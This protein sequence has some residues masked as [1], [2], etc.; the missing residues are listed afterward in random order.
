MIF[1]NPSE[2]HEPCPAKRPLRALSLAL[3]ALLLGCG[4]QVIV[5]R[6]AATPPSA[7]ALIDSD[8]GGAR[9][10]ATR[11]GGNEDDESDGDD[12][13]DD[14]ESDG[15]DDELGENDIDDDEGNPDG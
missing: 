3:A 9:T 13:D 14:D 8:A 2:A 11:D 10:P 4:E 7:E 15:D 6:E 1:E 12:D 5:G